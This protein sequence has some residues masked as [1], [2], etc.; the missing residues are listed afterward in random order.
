MEREMK[1][2]LRIFL[3]NLLII[4]TSLS[5]MEKNQSNNIPLFL[6]IGNLKVYAENWQN[7]TG[8]KLTLEQ[9]F[10]SDNLHILPG[11]PIGTFDSKGLHL[12][13]ASKFE[14]RDGKY[15]SSFL[16]KEEESD[17]DFEMLTINLIFEKNTNNLTVTAY[18]TNNSNPLLI[19]KTIHSA[20]GNFSF[21]SDIDINLYLTLT[22]NKLNQL[23][24]KIGQKRKF[25]AYIK[26]K[27]CNKTSS[28]SFC[29]RTT[30]QKATME[31]LEKIIF[32]FKI[33]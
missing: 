1:Y 3:S 21:S 22:L 14:I 24:I 10:F 2:L 9:S 30:K 27:T 5:S 7:E 32:F 23:N 26:I 6:S 16:I 8:K 25:Y 29:P 18:R 28:N 17:D 4:A 12:N 13:Q 20:E 19:G 11:K 15:L 33:R 31:I